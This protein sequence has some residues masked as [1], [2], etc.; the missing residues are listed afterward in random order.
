MLCHN[1][2]RQEP[3][4]M[5]KCVVRTHSCKHCAVMNL[6]KKNNLHVSLDACVSFFLCPPAAVNLLAAVPRRRPSLW[7]PLEHLLTLGNSLLQHLRLTGAGNHFCRQP[8]LDPGRPLHPRRLQ[9]PQGYPLCSSQ[10][11]CTDVR[12]RLRWTS[13]GLALND[14]WLL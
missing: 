2:E 8:R 3:N 6:I 7:M 14:L 9:V 10:A 12:N 13:F 4:I 5:D 11:R 1:R